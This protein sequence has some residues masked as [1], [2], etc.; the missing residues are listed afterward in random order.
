MSEGEQEFVAKWLKDLENV[1]IAVE[2][3]YL[4]IDEEIESSYLPVIGDA[5]KKAYCAAVYLCFKS[6]V[7]WRSVLVASKVRLAP[8]SVPEMQGPRYR[9]VQGGYDPLK[10]F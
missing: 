10:N 9:G 5:S 7:G 8:L 4:P 2:K 1:T 6:K 3:C